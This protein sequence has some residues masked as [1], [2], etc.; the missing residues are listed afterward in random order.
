MNEL[1]YAERIPQ[2]DRLFNRLNQ[3]PQIQHQ[4]GK[5]NSV[6]LKKNQIYELDNLNNNRERRNRRPA[7]LYP[8][9]RLDRDLSRPIFSDSENVNDA[10]Q[11]TNE[12]HTDD[13]AGC[14]HHWQGNG[15]PRE[16]QRHCDRTDSPV[17]ENHRLNDASTSNYSQ[18]ASGGFGPRGMLSIPTDPVRAQVHNN[19][20]YRDFALPDL[21]QRDQRSRPNTPTA[22]IFNYEGASDNLDT[23]GVPDSAIIPSAPAL[24]VIGFG[25]SQIDLESRLRSSPTPSTNNNNSIRS[26]TNDVEQMPPAYKDLFP[27][28][29]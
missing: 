21:A 18:S 3:A 29:K 16:N 28:E 17:M 4:N 15:R 12:G 19:Y 23:L 6:N 2:N 5:D 10:H 22:P 7:F 14:S 24:P 9:Q 25:L 13:Q 26:A 8:D 20:D 11:D 1:T 27:F